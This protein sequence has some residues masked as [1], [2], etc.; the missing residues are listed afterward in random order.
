MASL[1]C[2]TFASCNDYL[3][4][5]AP[6]KYDDK[7]V[8]GSE[9][10]INR[11]LNGVY[12]Q[13]LNSNVYGDKYL[14]DFC[15]N[16]DVDFTANS[17]ENSTSNGFKRFDCTSDASQ[18]KKTWDQAYSG[19]EYANN[20][21]YQ[22]ENSDLYK[23]DNANLYQKMGE[24][25]VIRAI[26]YNDLVDLWGDVPFTLTPTSQK[27]DYVTPIVSRDEIRA[28]LI[29]DLREIAPKMSYARKL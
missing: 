21:I 12:A 9:S 13:L 24:A 3:D 29:E 14:T 20:F 18:L 23:K 6:S 4:V 16:S 26:F 25:K 10:E 19:I 28:K 7:Y 17:T 1:A 22:L 15:L 27:G 8:F 11:A 5:D 2:A